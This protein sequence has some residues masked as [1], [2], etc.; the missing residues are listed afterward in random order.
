MLYRI[1]RSLA[2]L[3]F[4]LFFRIEV[5]GK[6]KVPKEGGFILASNHLSFLDPVVLGLA[7]PRRL[8][9]L[10]R[11]DLFTNKLFSSFIKKLG[12]VPLKREKPDITAMRIALKIIKNNCPLVIFPQGTRGQL[13]RSKPGVGF[14]FKRT[15][16]PIITAKIYGTDRALPKGARMIRFK[17]IKVFFD[18]IDN[19]E[20]EDDY[21]KI[22]LK[23]LEKIKV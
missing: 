8:Y 22:S 3:L 23:V 12:A 7:S 11:N 17:K 1:L 18:R 19:L 14:L 4:K 13:M 21:R 9:F 16:V 15:H 5:E 2:I 10:A 20:E 6:D